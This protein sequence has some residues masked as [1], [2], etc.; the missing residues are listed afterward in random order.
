MDLRIPEAILPVLFT[1][2]R[3]KVLYGGRG[4]AKSESA[5]RSLV[6]K[7]VSK[8]NRI[9]CAREYQSSIADSVHHTIADA[10]HELELSAY[11][12]ITDKTI[13]G[14]NGSDFIFKGLQR[15]IREIKS[16]KGITICWVEEAQGISDESWEL[17]IPTIREPESEIWITFNP[18]EEKD[19][20]YKRF[21]LH[22]PPDSIVK[23]VGWEH[24]PWF[25]EVLDKE[26]RAMLATDPDAYEH[27]W[28]GKCRHLTD[29]V[30]FGKRTKVESFET[31]EDARFFFGADFGF[32]N[33]PSCLIRSFIKEKTLFVDYESYGYGVEIDEL[34]QLYDDIPGSRQWPIKGDCSRPETISYV[35]RQGF[36][37]SG[38]EKWPGSVEDGIQ[39]LKGFEAIVIHERCKHMRDERTNYRFK[40]DPRTKEVLPIIVDAHNHGWD[41][42]RYS[43]GEYIQ[44]RGASAM[45]EKLAS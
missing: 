13:R 33:D 19:P 16:T 26:R 45:W 2:A 37:I 14:I 44:R 34:P 3:Y 41:S 24:N 1:P 25:P 32:A 17:L 31:P 23:K 28:G 7:A 39:H 35:S 5:A 4:A 9:L 42:I 40:V 20:T 43:L 22:P 29:A 12:R 27:V 21:V 38:A 36:R 15:S 8:K 6:V 11:F 30:I 10:I 18:L